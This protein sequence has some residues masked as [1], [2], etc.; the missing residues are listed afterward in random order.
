VIIS[1]IVDVN[2]RMQLGRGSY[3]PVLRKVVEMTN[4]PIFELGCGYVSTPYLHWACF[5]T[6][7]KLF[8][9][10]NH[11]EWY[12]FASKFS[13]DFHTVQRVDDWDKVD[14]SGECEVAFV[15][16]APSLRRRHDIPRLVHA[17]Y[18]IVHD[19]ENSQDRKYR[20]GRALSRYKYH[21]KYGGARGPATSLVSN[22]HDLRYFRV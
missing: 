2:V 18:V 20:F 8:T 17:H 15:D 3:M 11:P 22:L 9:F 19:T 21:F 12:G 6:K 16:H 13:C 5:V 7:R 4:G 10:E 1:Q 14:L